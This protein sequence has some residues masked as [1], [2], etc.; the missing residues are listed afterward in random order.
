MNALPTT[1]STEQP[2]AENHTGS[3]P[4]PL[5]FDSHHASHLWIWILPIG[6]VLL[7]VAFFWS[8][9][10]ERG[11]EF[12]IEFNEGHGIKPEDRL[13]HKGIEIGV[14]KRVE[15]DRE[16]SKIIVK[17]R[18]AEH[19]KNVAKEGSRFWIVRPQ[20]TPGTIAGLETILGAKYLAMEP[21]SPDAPTKLRFTGLDS[22]PPDVPPAGSLEL[23]LDSATRRGLA[24]GAPIQF[25]GYQIGKV[26]DLG[27]SSDARSVQTRC[28]IAPEFRDLVR[29][30]SKFWNRSGWRLDVGLTGVE[31]DAE[32][33][34]QLITGGIEMATP[35]DSGDIVNTGHRFVLHERPESDWQKWAPSIGFGIGRSEQLGRVPPPQRM[36]L[37]WQERSFGF[38]T[39]Q[40]KV[41]W[42]LPIDDQTLLCFRE[43]AFAPNS[44]L[45]GTASI[46][47]AGQSLRMD[48][49]F[50]EPI[51]SLGGLDSSDPFDV[52]RLPL[53][54]PLPKE[55][56]LWPMSRVKL[57]TI[58]TK[59]LNVI[60]IQDRVQGSIHID[61]SRL[62]VDGDRWHV[63]SS[64]GLGADQHGLPVIEAETSN[65]IGLLV[66]SKSETFVSLLVSPR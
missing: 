42:C 9:W 10:M 15:L 56:P 14:V 49:D 2:N 6:C 20:I 61:A 4:T 5:E 65:L 43:Q 26:I 13:K 38:R 21:G 50:R 40:Q 54:N 57:E 18:V 35:D 34:P 64:I 33:L 36:A 25:R 51:P 52:I 46:E 32:T 53:K 58:S 17:V 47:V 28:W 29:T 19:A 45:A 30:G 63:D 12:D 7:S 48:V 59:P 23:I 66:S 44:A 27:L 1:E 60:V 62:S 41:G 55:I 8:A 3:I 22:P 31:I 39:Q 37:R 11:V 24:P 16:L